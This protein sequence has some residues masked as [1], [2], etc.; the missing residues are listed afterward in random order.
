MR[1][2]LPQL[3]LLLLLGSAFG[4]NTYQPV[5]VGSGEPLESQQLTGRRALWLNTADSSLKYCTEAT[6]AMVCTNWQ[7]VSG[8]GAVADPL[9]LTG[10]TV[11][12][13]AT[14]TTFV[15]AFTG[16]VTGSLF[17]NATS[18][19]TAT[20]AT[21]ALQ[22]A[23]ADKGFVNVVTDCGLPTNGT[24]DSLA[25]MRTCRALYPGRHFV[26]PKQRAYG[27][28]TCDYTFTGSIVTTG[29]SATSEWYDGVSNSGMAENAASAVRLC[30]SSGVTA[31]EIP[32]AL[33]N[34]FT[35]SNLH[36]IGSECWTIATA[37]TYVLPF[38]WGGTNTA[39]GIRAH[40]RANL[41]DVTIECF[42]RHGINFDTDGYTGNLNSGKI[43]NVFVT[44]N[45]GMGLFI[46]G[47]DS[48]IMTVEGVSASF[49]QLDGINESSFLGNFHAAHH[50]DGNGTDGT[51]NG[52]AIAI[53]SST[54]SDS[55]ATLTAAAHGL[56]IGD[57][58]NISG[59]AGGRLT[60]RFVVLDV[61][62]ANTFV[63][64]TAQNDKAATVETA[65]AFKRTGGT[66]WKKA[67]TGCSITSGLTALT[68]D[69]G[70]LTP[71]T[72]IGYP[73]NIT[74]AGAAGANLV[75]FV[76]AIPT[77][78][79]AV[80][81]WQ[82][83]TNVMT[84]T[85]PNTFTVGQNV[86]LIGFDSADL[87]D[88]EVQTATVAA[89]QFTANITHADVANH[90]DVARAY[91][92]SVTVRDAAGTSV[93]GATG[94]VFYRSAAYRFTGSANPSQCSTCYS[95]GNQNA[96]LFNATSI[97]IG[98]DHGAGIDFNFNGGTKWI[99]SS[100][101]GL[102][103]VAPRATTWSTGNN[104]TDLEQVFQPGLA[105]TTLFRFYNFDSTTKAFVEGMR[106]TGGLSWTLRN[107][108][109]GGTRNAIDVNTSG[110]TDLAPT[111]DTK[112]LRLNVGFTALTG[113][114][115]GFYNG[116]LVQVGSVDNAG[117]AKF[118]AYANFTGTNAASGLYRLVKTDTICWRNNLNSADVCISLDGSDRVA[119]TTFA[120]ALFGNATTAS[121]LLA[122]GGNCAGNNFALGCAQPAFSNLSGAATDAQVPDNITVTLAA[123]A[124]ALAADPANC[125]AGSVAAGITAGGVAEGCA[126]FA[127]T[128]AA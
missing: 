94:T 12:G 16:N 99:K 20:T 98:G 125:A 28:A 88:G 15:G 17:G 36:L 44:N 101:N 37:A 27:S 56:V 21:T 25:A 70:G 35:V 65:S 111:L 107:V 95:E 77:V 30:F 123:T 68:C 13:T 118:S 113:T 4:Q 89:G 108:A 72:L 48:N 104:Q 96:A 55:Y 71:D 126:V 124:T 58:V 103:I 112:Q 86:K 47:A 75:T 23:I 24:S 102:E 18:A 100:G 62:T 81:A 121:A 64:Y 11:N 105:N 19:T 43:R 14:A 51:A 76:S 128:K 32:A 80:T 85:C 49:N 97:V 34:G 8:G 92:P 87:N 61:P 63:I 119:A 67:L 73:V 114:S 120:G 69:S 50:T 9:T 90:A 117:L 93:T 39:D 122:N 2:I 10:L 106:V 5:F 52:P 33:A 3:A 31:F 91:A 109:G 54:I 1:R 53:T 74:G 41:H 60:G 40:S 66:A 115:V 7:S 84:V 127:V 42:G 46:R 116:A 29:D 57:Y 79:C 78:F 45:R 22:D 83:V 38:G 110:N 26:F 6:T 59:S 82:I